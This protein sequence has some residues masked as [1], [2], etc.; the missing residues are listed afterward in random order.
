MKRNSGEFF[1]YRK[2]DGCD[3]T[4]DG[5]I[6]GLGGEMFDGGFDNNGSAGGGDTIELRQEFRFD[7]F[8]GGSNLDSGSDFDNDGGRSGDGAIGRSDSVVGSLRNGLVDNGDRAL[9]GS[10]GFSGRDDAGGKAE[11]GDAG[12]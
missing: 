6:G 2:P 12:G 8:D 9:S 10:G 5:F 3:C 7:G 4:S 11:S 1:W